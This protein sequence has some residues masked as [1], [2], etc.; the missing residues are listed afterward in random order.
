MNEGNMEEHHK[1]MVD[2]GVLDEYLI[3]NLHWMSNRSSWYAADIRIGGLDDDAKTQETYYE[4]FAELI[5]GEV[6]LLSIDFDTN[7]G[8]I[9]AKEPAVVGKEA[10]DNSQSDSAESMTFAYSY[11]EGHTYSYSNTFG[12]KVAIATDIKV[13]FMTG[14]VS[15]EGSYSGTWASGSSDGITKSYS[16]PLSVPAHRIYQAK[17]TVQQAT[18]EVPYSMKMSIGDHQW[19]T[20]GTWYGT[21]VS[22][23]TF[24]V[25]D[26]TPNGTAAAVLI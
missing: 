16:F 12:F 3:W 25:S 15:F 20:S 24:K 19:T 1:N 17:A 4:H 26:V 22:M 11:T 7:A 9:S 21:A 18:M 14:V 13:G 5:R 23:A 2:A 8:T 6:A 10:L